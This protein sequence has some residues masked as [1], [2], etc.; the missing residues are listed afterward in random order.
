MGLSRNWGYP[1]TSS[2]VYWQD[3]D[4]ALEFGAPWDPTFGQAHISTG[5]GFS[6]FLSLRKAD[7]DTDVYLGGVR[8]LSIGEIHNSMSC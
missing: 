3:Y 4:T 1:T 8:S 5:V 6:Y 7:R 2:H